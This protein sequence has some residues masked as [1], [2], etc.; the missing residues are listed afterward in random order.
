MLQRHG[1]RWVGPLA[2]RGIRWEF[3]RGL[4]HLWAHSYHAVR[5]DWA[6]LAASEVWEWVETVAFRTPGLQY[7]EAL[8]A[9][10]LLSHVEALDLSRNQFGDEGAAL[11]ADS[12]HLGR[13]Q[14]LDL[15]FNRI[16][17]RGAARL[18]VSPLMQRLA[19][20]RLDDNHLCDDGVEALLLFRPAA[21]GLTTLSLRWNSVGSLG[22]RALSEQSVLPHLAAL[23]L[24]NNAVGDDG[25]RAL[26]N[27]AGL[28]QL[29]ELRLEY[30]GIG[31]AATA[32]LRRRFGDGVHL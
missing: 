15:S 21:L 19:V 5:Q 17:H 30:N 4:L 31:A 7:A 20:L 13:L 26:A 18:A 23:H 1:E 3:R 11:L 8:F 25:A 24:G 6:D 12:P 27:A 9:S 22:A 28:R 14:S 10:P 32:A 2:R 29:T 16:G